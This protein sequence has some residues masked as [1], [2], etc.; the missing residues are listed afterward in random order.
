MD[1]VHFAERQWTVR[2]GSGTYVAT[3]TDH[4]R[5][6][7]QPGDCVDDGRWEVSTAAS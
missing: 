5:L 3:S 4:D 7:T 1:N 2:N 6:C